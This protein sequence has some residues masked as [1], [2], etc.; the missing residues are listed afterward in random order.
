MFQ[1]WVLRQ[2]HYMSTKKEKR[3]AYKP[4]AKNENYNNLR[5]A[6]SRKRQSILEWHSL[7][8]FCRVG[9]LSK[10][11]LRECTVMRTFECCAELHVHH[12]ARQATSYA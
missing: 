3:C 7:F 11:Q 2:G 6:R 10:V 4:A 5:E 1:P 8:E 12:S 9:L